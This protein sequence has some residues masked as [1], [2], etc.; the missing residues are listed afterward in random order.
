MRYFSDGNLLSVLAFFIW[1]PVTYY[2]VWRWPPAK[3]TATL[4]LGGL[5]LLPEKVFF[6]LSLIHI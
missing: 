3:A 5:L 4:F 1:I 2:G 6:K